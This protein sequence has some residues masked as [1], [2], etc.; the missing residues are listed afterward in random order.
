MSKI[1]ISARENGKTEQFLLKL[2]ILKL[3]ELDSWL[4]NILWLNL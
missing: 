2:A 1:K 4:K 3:F